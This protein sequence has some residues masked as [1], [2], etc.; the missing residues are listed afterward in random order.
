MS[1]NNYNIPDCIS[2]DRMRESR[3]SGQELKEVYCFLVEKD[4]ERCMFC[5]R[6]PPEVK[7]E[8]H[9]LDG[10]KNRHYY[11]NLGLSCHKCNCK[12]HPKGWKKKLK[13]Y[14]S[15]LAS[16]MPESSSA[17][18]RLKIDYVPK[19]FNYLEEEFTDSTLIRKDNIINIGAAKC[20][21]ASPVTI[22]RYLGLLTTDIGPFQE[23]KDNRTGIVYIKLRKDS[24]LIKEFRKKYCS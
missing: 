6:I 4:G 24:N 13:V 9:H 19:F 21:F 22:K 15:V 18:I 8:V 5:G 7:L 1:V 10:N 17:E 2:Y 11:K 14:V 3:L 20:G 16:N 12:H 23:W